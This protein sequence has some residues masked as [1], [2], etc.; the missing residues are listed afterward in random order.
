MKN[1]LLTIVTCTML[2]SICTFGLTA[3]GGESHTHAYKDVVT[4][5][6]C[7]EQGFTTHTCDCGDVVVDTYVPALGHTWVDADCTTAKTC[8]VCQATD[9]EAL[10]HS[11]TNYVY[12][13]DAKCGVNGTETAICDRED[14]NESHTREKAGSALQHS[15]TNYIYNN[16]AKCGVDGTETAICDRDGCNEED[17]RT[18]AGTALSHSF[19]NYVYNN[20]AKCGVDGTETAICDRDG[21]NEEDQRTK[22][23]TALSHSFTTYVADG[24]ATCLADGTKT[25]VCDNGCTETDTV[26]DVGSKKD[27]KYTNY[28]PNGDATYAADGTKTAKCDY[29]CNVG[30]DTVA[31]VGSRL[32]STLTIVFGNGAQNIVIND[33]SGVNVATVEDPAKTGYTFTGWSAEIPA[34]LPEGE[35]TITAN[36]SINQYTITIKLGNGDADIVI[37]KDYNA[38]IE[39]VEDPSRDN[40][41]FEGWDAEIPAKMPANDLTINAKWSMDVSGDVYDSYSA[42]VSDEDD[43]LVID[44]LAYDGEFIV[45]AMLGE[46]VLDSSAFSW[47]DNKLIFDQAIV[48]EN[49]GAYVDLYVINGANQL[50]YIEVLFA[51]KALKTATDVQMAFDVTAPYFIAS[52]AANSTIGRGGNIEANLNTYVLANDVD[53]TGIVMYNRIKENVTGIV[54]GNNETFTT[55]KQLGFG[56]LFDGRGHVISNATV[57]LNSA[58]VYGLESDMYY[59]AANGFF[60]A[61]L[62]GGVIKNVAFV[63]IDDSTDGL[64]SQ[65]LSGVL[66][67]TNYGATLENVFVDVSANTYTTRG[68]FSHISAGS[69]YTNVV[70][71]FA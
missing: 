48:D 68:V 49:I 9:G 18:K 47:N 55:A 10:N 32:K 65:G 66:G 71:N 14:C 1:K 59:G 38:D 57:A 39:A 63:N 35:T 36:W 27:H 53:M 13:N 23:G 5:A 19:T 62:K 60:Y 70:V 31:D 45:D 43:V 52:T 22:A 28:V 54:K 16:D 29:G 69:T 40:Y 11:Y 21:C 25:A 46:T 7:T 2:A 67:F 34:T 12:N 58:A 64:A 33:Y 17:Q 37:T 8:S 41:V 51:N 6:T 24:N 30:E 42:Y 50:I 26:A 4:P 15:F 61:I 56:G 3:C 44:E 20:D